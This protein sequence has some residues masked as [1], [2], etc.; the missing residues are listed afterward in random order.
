MK[1]LLECVPNISEGCDKAI[2]T[3]IADEIRSVEGVKLLNIDSGKAA[4]RTV[5]TFIGIPEKVVEAC[6]LM[7]KK[8]LELI[9]M[10]NHKGQ[11][12]R[13]GAVDVC[14]LVPVQGVTMDEA[15]NYAHQLGERIGQELKI[16]G[17]FYANASKTPNR[18]NLAVCRSGQYEGLKDKIQNPK[19]KPDFGPA[20]FT[21]VAEKFGAMM[22]SA[23]DFLVAY[24][25]NL[26]TTSTKIAND[27][28]GAIRES[29]RF[30][31][32][33]K[34]GKILKDSNGKSILIPGKL[35]AVKSIGWYIEDF[36]KVQVSCN[37]IDY[38]TTPMHVLFKVTV[39]E[40]K[41]RGVEVTG[42]EVIGLLPLKT[43][44]DAGKY[45]LE[46]EQLPTTVSEKKKIQI[47][48]QKM[49]LD[50]VKPFIP[51]KNIVEYAI[52]DF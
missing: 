36:K 11:H 25:L 49:G 14:P 16:S 6:F 45:F 22:I 34:T 3:A 10:R 43:L 31:R 27:I 35:K 21:E 37:L 44:L 4:N 42:S 2:I 8:A 26:D 12:P 15:V 46:K 48:I 41:K 32:D 40:A 30:K 39:E 19:W 51:E 18:N 38:K 52:R 1:R 24:N 5:Y 7:T 28:A 50:E 29:G 17:Y 13:L 23:R 33:E 9:D 47:A 20:E